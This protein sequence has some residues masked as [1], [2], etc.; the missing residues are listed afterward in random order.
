MKNLL[1]VKIKSWKL[2]ALSGTA[3]FLYHFPYLVGHWYNLYLLRKN[4]LFTDQ[5]FSFYE[6]IDS[7]IVGLVFYFPLY[8]IEFLGGNSFD[9]LLIHLSFVF[10]WFIWYKILMYIR[11][12]IFE[13]KYTNT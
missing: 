4:S 8:A 2:F 13:K 9:N 7:T 3:S 12:K 5:I 10:F 6:K 1:V 11:H